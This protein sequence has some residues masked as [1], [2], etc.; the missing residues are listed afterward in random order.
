MFD[1]HITGTRLAEHQIAANHVI[2]FFESEPGSLAVRQ[3]FSADNTSRESRQAIYQCKSALSEK[4]LNTQ[5]MVEIYKTLVSDRVPDAILWADERA[6][7]LAA[8]YAEIGR[9]RRAASSGDPL[10]QADSEAQSPRI[11]RGPTWGSR[12][13]SESGRDVA[14]DGQCPTDGMWHSWECDG[15]W[16]DNTFCAP[17]RN[18]H[19][20]VFCAT[21]YK[22]AQ[23]W[24]DNVTYFDTLVCNASFDVPALFW[25]QTWHSG[26][27][28]W[29]D[30][31]HRDYS[32]LIPPRRIDGWTYISSYR[33]ERKSHAGDESPN[34]QTRVHF[35]CA[36]DFVQPNQGPW[37][38]YATMN[39]IV[40]YQGLIYYNGTWALYG[41]VQVLSIENN[42]LVSIPFLRA[43]ISEGACIPNAINPQNTVSLAVGVTA[44]PDQMRQI[45]GNQPVTVTQQNPLALRACYPMNYPDAL[46]VRITYSR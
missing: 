5:S 42:S 12:V 17:A 43:G 35:M 29:N 36:K 4:S 25:S 22:W 30:H 10:L 23:D 7:R 9:I 18:E 40:P 3:R 46:S 6:A 16:F 13:G 11:T 21:N 34:S 31:W 39:R 27:D 19:A 37:T 33:W 1:E 14:F 45:F 41:T 26:L 8:L 2:T 28:W 32:A 24:R 20:D 15:I 44:S 38:D